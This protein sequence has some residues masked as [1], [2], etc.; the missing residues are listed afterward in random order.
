MSYTGGRLSNCTLPSY[1]PPHGCRLLIELHLGVALA[2][3]A[4][5]MAP[6]VLQQNMEAAR[7]A[8]D[9]ADLE[10][11]MRSGLGPLDTGDDEALWVRK[12]LPQ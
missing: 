2:G 6:H 5:R 12:C 11:I 1:A 4:A 3:L 7:A 9:E 8:A 10:R